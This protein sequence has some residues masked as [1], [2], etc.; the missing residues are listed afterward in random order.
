[1]SRSVLP[2]RSKEGRFFQDVGDVCLKPSGHS[3]RIVSKIKNHKRWVL[4]EFQHP[5]LPQ[6]EAGM[7]ALY[8]LMKSAHSP[9][10]RALYKTTTEKPDPEYFATVSKILPD[11]MDFENF[12]E[13]SFGVAGKE[14]KTNKALEFL[15]HNGFPEVCALSY[16]FEEDDFH[17][18]NIG[19]SNGSL[20]RIDLD[21]SAYSIVSQSHLRGVRAFSGSTFPI[22]TRDLS[23]FPILTDANPYYWPTTYRSLSAS[24]GYS[25]DEVKLFSTLKDNEV[26][27]SKSY[28]TFLKIILMPDVAIKTTLAAHISDV[29]TLE[30]VHAHFIARKAELKSQL[31]GCFKFRA[32]WKRVSLTEIQSL[33][34]EIRNTNAALKE[35]HQNLRVNLPEVFASY[36]DLSRELTKEGIEENLIFLAEL[37]NR[38]RREMKIA[39]NVSFSVD[40]YSTLVALRDVLFGVY[41]S[42][43]D[44]VHVSA[45]DIAGFV[46][47]VNNALTGFKLHLLSF[48]EKSKENLSEFFQNMER[49]LNQ[50][51]PDHTV[52]RSKVI[53]AIARTSVVDL[54]IEKDCTFMHVPT[55]NANDLV[56]DTV[57]WL[58]RSDNKFMV[59]DIF[60]KACEEYEKITITVTGQVAAGLYTGVASVFSLFYTK[61]T[62]EV[63]PVAAIASP[64]LNAIFLEMSGVESSDRL[65][66]VISRLLSQE[67]PWSKIVCE[68]FVLG[69]VNQFSRE[70]SA[71][72]I[73]EQLQKNPFFVEYLK[74]QPSNQMESFKAMEIA[75]LLIQEMQPKS[76]DS[77]EFADCLMVDHTSDFKLGDE[78][79]VR[80][81]SVPGANL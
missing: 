80:L 9:K 71:T 49:V 57:L 69:I 60:K 23:N 46:L 17:K 75:R 34:Q 70:F 29:A 56:H 32:W 19:V 72:H 47:K 5:L 67:K 51:Q 28:L 41:K 43:C 21:M 50:L 16:F 68:Q 3:T 38:Y 24:H 52:S 66:Q 26:F 39:T 25:A 14:G 59:M 36:Y 30:G 12:L 44:N 6:I 20:V 65:C 74:A 37:I 81:D 33:F 53:D 76:A 27:N 1:M 4:K 77:A 2:Q 22:T 7:A 11:F 42:F 54:I 78:K 15:I 31:M 58:R 48:P 13:S 73:I 40:I 10:M 63:S 61:P 35:Q 18:G 79:E 62:L 45:E 55:L 64:E 8:E